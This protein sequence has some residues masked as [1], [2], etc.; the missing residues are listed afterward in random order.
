MRWMKQAMSSLALDVDEFGYLLI[1][2]PFFLLYGHRCTRGA[3]SRRWLDG[4]FRTFR[5]FFGAETVLAPDR[6]SC[7]RLHSYR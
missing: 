7:S 4:D 1:G 6:R 5:E 3:S 2:L